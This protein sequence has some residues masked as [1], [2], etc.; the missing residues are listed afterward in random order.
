M[1]ALSEFSD[2]LGKQAEHLKREQDAHQAL[3]ESLFKKAARAYFEE[4]PFIHSLR[5]THHTPN[6]NDGDPCTFTMSG[7]GLFATH[8]VEL[9]ESDVDSFEAEDVRDAL[10]DLVNEEGVSP[11]IKS[12]IKEREA[13]T[14]EEKSSPL[15]H[16]SSWWRRIPDEG[17]DLEVWNAVGDADRLYGML[18]PDTSEDLFGNYVEVTLSKDGATTAEYYGYC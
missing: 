6:F 15:A 11:W 18:D 9:A 16:G 10:S 7:Y 8:D 4:Y 17:C 12:R 3:V 2:T 5:W 13:V 1:S 14:D